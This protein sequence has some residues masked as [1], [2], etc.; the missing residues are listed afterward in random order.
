MPRLR[1]NFGIFGSTFGHATRFERKAGT[2]LER[3]RMCVEVKQI[4]KCTRTIQRS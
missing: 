1:W 2:L 4:H 3:L